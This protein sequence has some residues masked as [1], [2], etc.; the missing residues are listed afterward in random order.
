MTIHR[1]PRLHRIGTLAM[2]MWLAGCQS[3]PPQHDDG[4]LQREAM[5]G[6]ENSVPQPLPLNASKTAESS[7]VP[8]PDVASGS[9][10]FIRTTGLAQ[11]R[12]AASG[13]GA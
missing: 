2:A 7:V 5:A 11:P 3:L 12:K 1:T 4:A 13:D 8:R 6:T 10:Q 9:G